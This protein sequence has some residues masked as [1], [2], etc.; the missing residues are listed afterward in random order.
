VSDLLKTGLAWLAGKRK[1]KMGTAVSYV[2]EAVTVAVTATIART[3]FLVEDSRGILV[4]SVSRDYLI[5]TADLVTGGAQITPVAGHTIRETVGSAIYVYQ[6]CAYDREG[7]WRWADPYR[8]TRRVHTR[9]ID[10]EEA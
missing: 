5:T 8:T 10:K 1:G 9:Y 3:V 4:R 6:V 7:V 2:A